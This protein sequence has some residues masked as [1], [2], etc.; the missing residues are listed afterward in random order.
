MYKL[1][2]IVINIFFSCSYYSLNKV[3]DIRIWRQPDGIRVVFDLD[4]QVDYSK[5]F[6]KNP[7]RLVIDLNQVSNLDG[8]LKQ[9]IQEIPKVNHL[10]NK[11]RFGYYQNKDKL[12]L[13]FDLDK[14]I[15]NIDYKVFKLNPNTIYSHRLVVD[16]NIQ[17]NQNQNHIVKHNKKFIIAIDAG[18]GGEDPG[19]IGPGGT[20]EKDVTYNIAKNLYNYLKLYKDIEPILI[21][22]GDYYI[23]LR[24]RIQLARDYNANLFISIHADGF[25]DK[26]V[27][28]ASV[29]TLSD[30]GATSELARWLADSENNA[31]L[32]GGVNLDDKDDMLAHVLLD[33][34]QTAT[35]T[36]SYNLAS[37]V[38]A[39]LRNITTIHKRYVEQAGFL[40]LKSPDIP[41]IL[42]ETGFISNY[43]GELKLRSSQFQNK[44]AK[45]I[46]ESI[47]Q[48]FNKFEKYNINQNKFN[49]ILQASN[50]KSKYQ[51][52]S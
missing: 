11:T 9:K 24:K 33:L 37:T 32:L 12:R 38:L 15:S 52:K 40:V 26:R 42:I 35:K 17:E 1:I 44:I 34:S 50:V 19:A 13:V 2:F 47:Y 41:S 30:K 23:G 43:K 10:L 4:S 25:T 16:L 6:L 22:K 14:N 27:H 3:Q 8:R 20:Y 51:N 5:I 31:D 49:D 21:R 48:Y 28:G 45:N 36:Y 39:S 29:F 18:H 7:S 46:A